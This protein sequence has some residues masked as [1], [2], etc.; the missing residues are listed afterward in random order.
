MAHALGFGHLQADVALVERQL[1]IHPRVD[2]QIDGRVRLDKAG[3]LPCDPVARHPLGRGQVN[4][5]SVC[6][7]GLV[8]DAFDV[9]GGGLHDLD[10]GPDALADGGQLHAFRATGHKAGADPGFK[11]LQTPTHGWLSDAELASGAAHGPRGDQ[12]MENTQIVPVKQLRLSA[13]E[14]VRFADE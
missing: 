6:A 11:L 4:G 1:A 5:A 14:R 9:A 12:R 10:L 7:V 2:L 13:H 8:G 3:Q